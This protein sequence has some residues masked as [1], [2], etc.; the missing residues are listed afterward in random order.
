MRVFCG[1]PSPLLRRPTALAIGNFDGVH[2][3]HQSLLRSVVQAAADRGLQPACVTFEPHPRELF[4]KPDEVLPRI[5][6]LYDKVL[7]ILET[8]IQR[9]Y[10]LPFN[11]HLASLRAEA[12]VRD[13]LCEGLDA[14]WITVGKDFHFGADRHGDVELLETLSK[15][16]HYEFYVAPT[17][18]HTNARVSSSRIREAL[19]AGDLV[20]A[21]LMLGRRYSMTGRVIH[22]AALGRTLG[23]P[24][25]NMAT[26]PPGSCAR[27][28]V[29]GVYAVRIKGLGRAVQNG[30]A[31][32]GRKPTVSSDGRWLLE[33][34]VFD[35]K[36]DA[37]G[38]LI[39][40]EFIERLREE[41][42]FSGLEEL[43]AAIEA[44]AKRARGILGLA[45]GD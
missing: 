38:K 2:T 41:K 25:L 29:T 11:K 18:F 37:Y 43:T 23:Y 34:H 33:T 5:S 12:F 1:L 19:L 8:G 3:G 31:S 13:V 21:S 22:G 30:V 42:K 32:V 27:P 44:D 26:V 17:L 28:A 39:E 40:V 7:R 16:L 6:T 35:W 4:H 24:T 45:E 20:E 14:H 10:I 15:E 9:V 36:G